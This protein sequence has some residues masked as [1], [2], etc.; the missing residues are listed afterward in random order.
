MSR[1]FGW[2]RD[3]TDYRDFKYS[4]HPDMQG[5]LSILQAVDLRSKMPPIDDQ[6]QAGSCVA[7]ASVGNLEYL[8]LIDLVSHFKGPE[9]FDASQYEQLSR[10]F[11]YANARIYDGDLDQDNGT[12]LRSAVMTLKQYGVCEESL[13]PYDLSQKLFTAP[14][15]QAYEQGKQHLILTA[16]KIDN[17]QMSQMTQCLAQG[18]PFIFGITVYSSFMSNDVA[19]TG[20]VPMPV[21][22][23]S[24]EGGHALCCVGF[25][26]ETKQFIV[27][28]SW[29]TNWG[30]QGY[31]MI[32][33]SYL[34]NSELASDFWTIRKS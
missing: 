7:N 21:S 24:V 5:P 4:A 1:K 3:L 13:W 17:T 22:N 12:Q 20:I 10:M 23:D 27:R 29:G 30:L 15:T 26:N 19:S 31:C 28:N 2:K 6:G 25:D 11:V 9:V 8:E 32:P 14:S 18:Y 34:T 16:H 33:Y